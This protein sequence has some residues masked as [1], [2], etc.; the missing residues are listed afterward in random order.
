MAQTSDQSIEYVNMYDVQD[1]VRRVRKTQ[2]NGTDWQD[3][4][5]YRFD[6]ALSTAEREWLQKTYGRSGVHRPGVYW[7]SNRFITVMDE[8]IYM[9]F[10][11]KFG[12]S[13]SNH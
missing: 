5:Q 7:A 2:W 6:R 11:L 13:D 10:C 3:T 4:V 1:K 8:Q 9:I 12:S